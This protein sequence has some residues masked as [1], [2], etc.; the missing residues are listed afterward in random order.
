LKKRSINQGQMLGW[1]YKIPWKKI[2]HWF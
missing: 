1:V 2:S